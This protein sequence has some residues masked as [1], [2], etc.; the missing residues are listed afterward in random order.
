MGE[1]VKCFLFNIRCILKLRVF[2]F[3]VLCGLQV[4]SK[5]LVF[6]FR[7]LSTMMAAFRILLS[8]T[9]YGFSGFA[10]EVHLAVTLLKLQFQWTTV[11]V[12]GMHENLSLLVIW[13]LTA[14]K[15]PGGGTRVTFCWVC[16]A[17]ISEPHYS[18]LCGQL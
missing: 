10:K 5:Y 14:A 9:F 18:L 13:V 8:S 17:G 7:F 1:N 4:F 6:G 15:Q 12:R 16:A 11:S 3:G 2:G